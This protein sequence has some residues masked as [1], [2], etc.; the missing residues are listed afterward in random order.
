MGYPIYSTRFIAASADGSPPAYE[1]PAG[2]I[3]IVR[4][5][6]VTY[7]GGAIVT[8]KVGIAAGATFWWDQFTVESIP[9]SLQWRG[10]QVLFAGEALYLA[11]DGPVDAAVSGY[12]LASD[13]RG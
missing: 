11:A 10:R 7:G 12:L 4:D 3:V 5:V 6:A 2:S 9:Q 1:V 13:L 8:V